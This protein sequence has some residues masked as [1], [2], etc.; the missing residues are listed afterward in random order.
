MAHEVTLSS[1]SALIDLP[2]TPVCQG[3]LGKC[4]DFKVI[5]IHIEA[6][7]EINKLRRGDDQTND[8]ERDLW[9]ELVAESTQSCTR[10]SKYHGDDVVMFLDGLLIT[11]RKLPR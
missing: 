8:K 4:E 3:R 10:L 6:S 1:V 9:R 5:K 7:I 11:K 2:T